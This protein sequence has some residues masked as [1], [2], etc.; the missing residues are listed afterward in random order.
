MS[1]VQIDT[2]TE[3]VGRLISAGKQDRWDKETSHL[4]ECSV[5]Q[6]LL[7]DSVA[8]KSHDCL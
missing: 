2:S 4:G 5:E 6:S 7:R 1:K 8:G 3:T